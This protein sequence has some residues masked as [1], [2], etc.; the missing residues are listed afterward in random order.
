MNKYYKKAALYPSIIAFIVAIAFSIIEN[1]N[2]KSEWL[3]ADA[4]I[5]LSIIT[6]FVY[7]LIFCLLSLTIFLNR[8]DTIRENGFLNFLSWFLLPFGFM[9]IV[10]VHEITFKIRYNEKFESDFVF[11][12]ILNFPFLFGLIWSYVIYKRANRFVE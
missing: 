7:C 11:V 8:F 10:F 3:T 5:S 2:Y 9:T 1:Y 12:L 4:V 6:A